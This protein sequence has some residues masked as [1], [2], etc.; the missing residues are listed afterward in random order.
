MDANIFEFTDEILC[1]ALKTHIRNLTRMMFIFR[2]IPVQALLSNRITEEQQRL[3][4]ERFLVFIR[5]IRMI[6]SSRPLKHRRTTNLRDARLNCVNPV[7]VTPTVPEND[8]GINASECDCMAVYKRKCDSVRTDYC[9]ILE[10]KLEQIRTLEAEIVTLKSGN[11]APSDTS[12]FI[13]EISILCRDI[14]FD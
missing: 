13:N 11:V 10:Q 8:R 5:E 9:M 3:M 14:L 6:L 7:V 2:L 1:V 4:L 12:V